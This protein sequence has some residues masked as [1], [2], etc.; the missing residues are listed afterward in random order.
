MI[1]TQ[2]SSADVLPPHYWES[3]LHDAQT[4]G[5]LDFYMGEQF[6]RGGGKL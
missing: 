2:L 1:L 5:T 3:M 6:Q 4:G